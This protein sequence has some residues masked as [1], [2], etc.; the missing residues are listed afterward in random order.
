MN[1]RPAASTDQLFRQWRSGD[2][3]AG[4]AM[5]Q[6][7]TDWF[8]AIAA[9]RLGETGGE[10]PFQ[11]A[12]QRFSDGVMRVRSPE[13]LAPW[14]HK[15]ILEEIGDRRMATDG[16]PGRFT[17]A[18]DPR[19][20]LRRASAAIPQDVALLNAVYSGSGTTENP[21]ELAHA[22]GRLK[23]WLQKHAGVPFRRATGAD[24]DHAP[25]PLYECGR[26]ADRRETQAVERWLLRDNA[27]CQDVAEFAHFA[28]ALRTALPMQAPVAKAQ[29]NQLAAPAAGGSS[30][31]PL[32][33]G[34][35]VV[36]AI[37]AGALY[38]LAG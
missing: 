19:E 14:A 26:L 9:C 20:L 36:A 35:L 6:R 13:K 23:T 24:D 28:I 15:V 10:G 31:M 22:R 16:T 30:K 5:A 34:G 38:A 2:G 3:E 29:P 21:V 12:C 32:I 4:R 17:N 8:F 1:L 11:A 18:Q 7:F 33:I 37:A 25:L 27:V